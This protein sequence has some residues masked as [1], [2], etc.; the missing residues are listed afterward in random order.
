MTTY[1]EYK[2][3]PADERDRLGFAKWQEEQRD[4]NALKELARRQAEQARAA[5]E[6]RRNTP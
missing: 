2:R 4:K 5:R 3:L 1:A 6:H